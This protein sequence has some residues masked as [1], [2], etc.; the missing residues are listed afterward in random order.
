MQRNLAQNRFKLVPA[1]LVN[2]HISLGMF[3]IMIV[4]AV[5][6]ALALGILPIHEDIADYFESF[7]LWGRISLLGPWWNLMGKT[8]SD[9]ARQIVMTFAEQFSALIVYKIVRVHDCII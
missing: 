8:P 7:V 5:L 2:E 4:L 1:S 3:L 9:N 6:V